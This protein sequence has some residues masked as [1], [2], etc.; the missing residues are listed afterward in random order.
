MSTSQSTSPQY[1]SR[2]Q[3]LRY[4]AGGG[5]SAVALNYLLPHAA[6]SREPDLETLCASFPYNSRCENYLPGVQA[7]DDT[8][9][10]IAVD[11]LLSSV[12][13]DDRILSKGLDR[14]AYLVI[15]AGPQIASYGISAVCT[16][17]G[18][19]VDW[20]AT[21]TRFECPCHGSQYDNQ[22]KVIHGP[23]SRPLHLI[24]VV[25]KQNQVRLVERE[26]AIDPRS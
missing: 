7:L 5:A 6:Q 23:A 26:P 3:F 13:A 15:E 14:E 16:H 20:N 11:A 21:E 22:G 4:L 18:C 1:R 19:T 10:P 25:V 12:Q 17:L 8:E 9:Q 2:R 24:T